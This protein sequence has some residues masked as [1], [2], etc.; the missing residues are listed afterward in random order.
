L[1]WHPDKNKG[2]PIA[3]QM[4][5]KI[6]K[7]YEALTDEKAKANYE[8]FGNPD[9]KQALEVSIGLPTFMLEEDNHQSILVVYLLVLV[10]AIPSVV[11]CWYTRSKEYG[12][13]NV[14]YR[15]YEFYHFMLSEHAHVKMMPETLAGS[16]EYGKAI[17]FK[18]EENELVMG[19][20][21]KLTQDGQ[22]QKE[23]CK[24][25][26]TIVK[27][28]LLIHAYLTG[29]DIPKQLEDD[30]LEIQKYSMHLT[31]AM[32]ELSSQMRWLQT[33]RFIIEFSQLMTQALWVKDSSLMQIPHFT[34]QEVKHVMSGRGKPIKTAV[35][36]AR[37]EPDERKGMQKFTDDQKQDVEK[38]LK[39]LPDVDLELT[40]SVK[41]E[42]Q[43]AEQDFVTLNIKVT[44]NNVEEGEEVGNVHCPKFP[45][46]KKESWWFMLGSGQANK[47]IAIKQGKGQGKVVEEQIQFWAPPKAG[48]YQFDVYAMNDSY[49]GVDIHRQIKME[50]IPSTNLPTY[51]AHEEDLELDNEPTLFE[52]VMTGNLE[53]DTDSDDDDSSSDDEVELTD[54]QRK[55]KAKRLAAKNGGDSSDDSDSDGDDEDKKDK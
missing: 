6:A 33:T 3:E 47:L 1:E 21:K 50:V 34:S 7:A 53:D 39:I 4:F 43:I 49:V 35:A 9:G 46:L 19:L 23:K 38:F 24:S 51:Q 2:N 52:Q 44:R 28:N 41:D 22:M 11:C 18:T 26:P 12:E 29:I 20:Y 14:M 16:A 15:S 36:Y 10:V 13:K 32:L 37:A 8:K 25:R 45:F 54:A 17:P 42:N 40:L 55:K 5:M 27:A 48:T 30:L 31:E